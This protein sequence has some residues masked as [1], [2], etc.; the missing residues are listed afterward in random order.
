MGSVEVDG[1]IFREKDK[2]WLERLPKLEDDVREKFLNKLQTV[3][4]IV[5]VLAF[6]SGY[7]FSRFIQGV[8]G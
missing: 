7:C 2:E 3:F 6:L 8:F 5:V 4:Y 1:I